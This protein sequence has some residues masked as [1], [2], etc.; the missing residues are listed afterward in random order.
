FA[1]QEKNLATMQ[2][3]M[4][5]LIEN[6]ARMLDQQRIDRVSASAKACRVPAMKPLFAGL[7]DVLSQ[8]T[9]RKYSL[10]TKDKDGKEVAAELT[11]TE[12]VDSIRDH[13][14]KL[15]ATTTV[16][17]HA[18]RGPQ[19]TDDPDA[20]GDTGGDGDIG[21]PDIEVTDKAKALMD[22]DPNLKFAQATAKVLSADA[23]LR[24]RYAK[25]TTPGGVH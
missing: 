19:P 11:G 21:R 25:F 3:Q 8:S 16:T 23:E 20:D 5:G 13:V 14:N 17:T 22:K 18:A 10:K 6:N 1:E 12:L 15:F 4:T 2:T 24:A 7:Y 9:E